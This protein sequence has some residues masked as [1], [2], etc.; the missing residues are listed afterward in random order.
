MNTVIPAKE[1]ITDP[2]TV[3]AVQNGIV[4]GEMLPEAQT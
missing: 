1:T 3:L 2:E 4:P